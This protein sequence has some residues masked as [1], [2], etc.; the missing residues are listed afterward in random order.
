MRTPDFYRYFLGFQ[1]EPRLH[2][3]FATAGDRA[4]QQ[5][6]PDL[7]HLTLCVISETG[8][9]DRFLLPQVRSALDDQRFSSFPVRLGRVGGSPA[10]AMVSAL[11]CQ[12]EIQDFYGKLTARLAAQSIA[13]LHRKSGLRAHVTLGHEPGRFEPFKAPLAWLPA[14]LLLIESLVGWSRHDVIARWPLLPPLARRIAVRS[15]AV[16]RGSSVSPSGRSR[17]VRAGPRPR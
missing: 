14:E 12:H 1:P 7:L 16:M 6:R 10:G 13:P 9:R 15:A 2:P 4:G 3:A 11:G 5:V 8:E 17:A